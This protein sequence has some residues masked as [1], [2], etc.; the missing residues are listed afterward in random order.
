MPRIRRKKMVATATIRKKDVPATLR[1]VRFGTPVTVTAVW[2][3]P[4]VNS[5]FEARTV[6]IGFEACSGVLKIVV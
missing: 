4:A 3:C 2:P 6:T 1:V 5:A